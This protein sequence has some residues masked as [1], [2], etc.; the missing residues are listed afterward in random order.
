MQNSQSTISNVR[1]ISWILTAAHCVPGPEIQVV[2]F[3][4]N[5]YVLLNETVPVE[6]QFV[7]PFDVENSDDIGLY[8]V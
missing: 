6:N 3:G 4:N 5:S 7:H 8:I 1:N 2:A